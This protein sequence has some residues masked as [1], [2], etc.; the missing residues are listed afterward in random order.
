MTKIRVLIGTD[1]ILNSFQTKV[2]INDEYCKNMIQALRWD[3]ASEKLETFE[4]DYYKEDYNGDI[5]TE[6]GVVK[7]FTDKYN[8]I[9]SNIKIT[10]VGK[11]WKDRLE[12]LR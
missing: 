11:H 1:R 7:L 12:A 2:F 3:I 8:E 9:D 6:F 4:I 10:R 5:I